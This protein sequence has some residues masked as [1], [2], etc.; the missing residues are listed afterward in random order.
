M[1]A[2]LQL[3][4]QWLRVLVRLGTCPLLWNQ[5]SRQAD[6]DYLNDLRF[7]IDQEESGSA[8]TNCR[9]FDHRLTTSVVLHGVMIAQ[10]RRSFKI[11]KH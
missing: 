1:A 6:H 11:S 9:R 5:T 8:P 3:V 7:P 2:T 4:K 10:Q